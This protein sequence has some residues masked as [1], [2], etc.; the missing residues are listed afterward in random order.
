MLTKIRLKNFKLHAATEIEAA[1]VTVF[2]GPNNSGKS[3]VFQALLLWRQAALGGGG[4]LCRSVERQQT[5]PAQPYL[6]VDSQLVDVGEFHHVVRRGQGEIVLGLHG[7]V[8][9]KKAIK[10]ASTVD[11]EAE[12]SVRDNSIAYHRGKLRST[13]ADFSWKWQQ[14]RPMEQATVHVP[15]TTGDVVLN[16]APTEGFGLISGGGS[17][18]PSNTPPEEVADVEELRQHLGN[19]VIS[20]VRS[21]HAVLPLRGLE[22]WGYPLTDVPPSDIDRMTL[23]DRTIALLNL[24]AYNFELQDRLSQWL[25]E[26]VGISIKVKLLPRKRL[27]LLS[28]PSGTRAVDSLFVNEGTGASQL[29]FILVPIGLTPPGET[30]LL[31]EPEV[32]LHPRVQTAL[33]SLLLT[34]AQKENRQF[35]VETHSE[36]ILHALLQAVTARTLKP[37]DLAIY[38]FDNNKG[39]AECKRLD[40]D[41]KGC[42]EGGLPGF[43]EHSLAELSEYL[44]ALKRD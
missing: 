4:Y 25:A 2:I 5:T 39:V 3:S 24:L 28:F 16:F 35:I 36:H 18:Y 42:V 7:S 1:P 38:Y 13:P 14:R 6:F 40:V 27:T 32:H 21:L 11:L 26:L 41:E 17:T 44:N 37:A 12:V 29:P 30:I 9:P 23:P 19:S 15:V 20:L 22:E 43:F 10:R 34:I 33:V 31:S 8:E